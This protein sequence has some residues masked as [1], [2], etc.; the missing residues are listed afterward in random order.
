MQFFDNNPAL[1]EGKYIAGGGVKMKDILN[2]QLGEELPKVIIK[3]FE[4]RR[5]YS[6]FK[7]NIVGADLMDALLIGKFDIVSKYAW[8]VPLKDKKKITTTNAFQTI[9][10]EFKRNKNKIWVDKYSNFYRRSM[11]WGLLGNNNNNVFDK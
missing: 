10:N 8:L 6:S 9:L 4:K 1:L 11:K 5:A 2:Q 3:K 7:D